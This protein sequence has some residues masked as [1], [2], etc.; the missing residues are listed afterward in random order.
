MDLFSAGSETTATTLA[1]AV[2]FCIIHPEVYQ[3]Y[4]I[5][6]KWQDVFLS[7]CVLVAKDLDNH[8][9]D[10]VLFYSWPS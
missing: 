3:F 1:W 9:T 7:V 8:L 6:E 5:I 4:V 10:M 2:A